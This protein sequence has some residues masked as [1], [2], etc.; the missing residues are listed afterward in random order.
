MVDTTEVLL[1]FGSPI[2]TVSTE[3]HRRCSGTCQRSIRA[4]T[5][6]RVVYWEARETNTTAPQFLL[7]YHPQPPLSF[8]RSYK[9]HVTPE[10]RTLLA[11]GRHRKWDAPSDPT[12]PTECHSF[13]SCRRFLPRSM[14]PSGSNFFRHN[15]RTRL[16]WSLQLHDE[17]L[18]MHGMHTM[19]CIRT[20][21]LIIY[22]LHG[23]KGCAWLRV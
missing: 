10:K 3:L 11:R 18:C 14:Q 20:D 16:R 17:T 13:V 19:R 5:D 8:L 2:L 7:C 22:W 9:V 4:T 1:Y 21:M 15:V 12:V 6:L 23:F